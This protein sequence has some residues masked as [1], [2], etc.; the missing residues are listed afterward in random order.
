MN[1]L[2]PPFDNVED[3]PGRDAGAQ[4]EGCSRRADR[5]SRTTTRSAAPSSS[6][7]RRTR[8]RP[9]ANAD[10]ARPR[11]GEGAARRKPAMTASRSSSCSR[12]TSPS[13]KAQP[14]VAAQALRD[15]GFKVDLQSM[16]WQTLVGRR[17]KPEAAEGRRL[18]HV[19]HHLGRRRHAEPDRQ[20][21]HQRPRQ[22]RAAGSA[23]RKTPRSRSCATSSRARPRRTSRR[24]SRPRSRRK[25]TSR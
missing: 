17:A 11:E 20:R 13:L 25:P 1:W 2:H 21:R 4:P 14:I 8:P 19:P 23:G 7:A 3:P 22:D 18:E 12:P 16:D 6:A 10:K 5:R 9:A 15:A 24:R